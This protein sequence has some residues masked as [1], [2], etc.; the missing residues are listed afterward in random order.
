MKVAIIGTQGVPAQYGGFETLVENLI[1][2]NCPSDIQYTVFCSSKDFKIQLPYYK[3]VKL[4]YV[5]IKANGMQS[6]PYDI[7]SFIKSVKGFDTVLVLGVSGCVFLPVFRL[8]FR[9]NLIVNIDGLEHKRGKWGY[10][11]KRFLKFS[12]LMAVK[13]AN[14]TVVDNKA[15]QDY[16]SETYR[17]SST[18]IEYGGDHAFRIVPVD[19][20]SEIMKHYGVINNEYAL[21]ICRI[22]PENNCHLILEAFAKSNYPIVFVGNWEISNY[23]RNLKQQY[24]P[25]SNIHFISSLY[26]LDSLYALRTN[27]KFYVHGHSAGGTNP[28]LVEAMYLGLPVVS[29]DVNYNKETTEHKSMYFQSVDDLILFLNK[30]ENYDLVAVGKQMKSIAKR[31][32]RWDLIAKKYAHII[33]T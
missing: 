13:F 8:F 16:V 25:Y 29:F 14:K 18:L 32:Y 17:K 3:G 22:E 26:D 5:P 15:I 27:C 7:V 9:G 6:I 19:K 20:Q 1:G 12:E 10:F 28:S 23:S 24:Q 31:R 30:I 4:R 11:T 21:A 2:E 33:R